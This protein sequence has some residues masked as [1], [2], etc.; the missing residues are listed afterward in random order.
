MSTAAYAWLVIA[1][2]LVA[3]NLPFL[4]NRVFGVFKYREGAKPLWLRLVELVVLYLAVGALALLIE[5]QQ[6]QRYPQRWE[7]YAVTA[8]LFLTFA[9]PGFVY[10]YLRKH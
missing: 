1:V 6:G 10:R 4:S 3:A 8:T 7:F 9:F 5:Y 2:A